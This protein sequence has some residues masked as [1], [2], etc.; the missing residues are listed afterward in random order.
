[1]NDLLQALREAS[2]RA[3]PPV[4]GEVRVPG[5]GS[6]VEIVRDR[7]GVPHIYASDLHD[8]WF[9]QGFVVASE[10]LFQIDLMSR[11]GAGRLAELFGD[12]VLPIDRF[13]RTVG[14][15]RAA[16]RA[17]AGYDERSREMATAFWSGVRA[18]T[19]IMEAPPVEYRF[20]G[21][22]PM[23][24]PEGD[25]AV[26]GASASAFMAW[27]LS[28]NWDNELLRGEIAERLGAEVAGTLFPPVEPE[29]EAVVAAGGPDR[30]AMLRDAHLPPSGQ[31][32]NNWVVDGSRTLTGKP[33]LAN[34]PHLV[35][36]LPSIW[37]ECHLV[38]PGIDVSGVS[39]PFS[40]G[41]VI[42]HNDRVAWGFTNTE[43][44]VQDLYVERL[45]EDGAAAEF[46]GSWE[47]LRVHREEIVVR[48]R[49]EPEILE[50]RESRHG[51]LID[52]YMVGVSEPTVVEG[53]LRHTY[54]LRWVGAEHLIQPSTL[55][56]VNAAGSWEAFRAAVRGWLCPGQNMVY[57]D[58]DGNIGYQA[59]GLYPVRRE[60]DGSV[61]VPGWTS[62]FEW[63]G[64]IP[65]DE[66][67]RSLNP[68]RGYICTANNRIHDDA[69]PHH[70]GSDFLPP[71][72]ARRIAELITERD[73][74]DR[75]SFAR[76]QR[77]TLSLSA[78]RIVPDLLRIEPR[79]DRQKEALSL[80][81]EWDRRLE[82]DSA[83]AALYEVW[84]K[85][86]A[87]GVLR[88]VL[89]D[90][91]LFTHFYA[92]RQWTNAFHHLVLPNLLAFPSARWFGRNGVEARD[93]VLLQ[94]L[95]AALEE[96]AGALGEDMPG[97]RWGALHKAR[98]AGALARV[99]DL[100]PLFTAGEVEVG[101]DEQTINQGLFEPGWS[102]DAVVVPSWRGILDP[103]DWDASVGSHT[104]G[105]SGHPASPHFADLL[106]LWAKG[107]HHPMPFSR[108]AVDAAAES[109]FR[110]A[111]QSQNMP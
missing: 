97:W 85:H 51:P 103:S 27:G 48:G 110:L 41:V 26:V 15:N 70:L 69:Y 79:S 52:S 40:P 6:P 65:F 12:L 29:G 31:G 30:L 55:H 45:S 21:L 107:E 99:P 105:Q 59:T 25:E 5:L 102:Y 94:A 35:V 77:D 8:L 60:G 98:F 13:A 84:V 38:G 95:D 67:P 76:I 93:E 92:R 23:E 58:V 64:W 56:L 10:R 86:I 2:R 44:D 36:Q 83:P 20:L 100:A 33:L 17:A 39:L 57:A 43:A 46:E 96:L 11:L 63:D 14:W 74:H 78:R 50:V 62:R 47:P 91:A 9:A 34:D 19:G 72:R 106:E 88:P 1:M 53:E 108:A 37:F 18:W 3:L 61:P 7:W 104:V 111:P 4:E 82:A 42:G 66:L 24:I 89:G 71:Y 101:G 75:D 49:D 28:R 32:S 54:A 80:L 90:E 73:T 81:A 109:T 68:E 16:R 22:D 87:T